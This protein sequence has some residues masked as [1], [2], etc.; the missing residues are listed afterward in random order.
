MPRRLSRRQSAADER[1]RRYVYF[2]RR[3]E[4]V[5]PLHIESAKRI[6]TSGYEPYMKCVVLSVR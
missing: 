4:D 1:A 5:L 6:M 3:Y 2:N